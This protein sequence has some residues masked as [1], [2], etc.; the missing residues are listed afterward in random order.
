M[1]WL[2]RFTTPRFLLIL[3]T[4][5]YVNAQSPAGVPARPDSPAVLA[6]IEKAKQAA[7]KEWAE[8]VTFFCSA[9]KASSAT[10]PVMAPVRLFDNLY[11][12]GRLSNVG[13]AITTPNGIILIDAG[14]A[15][16]VESVLLAG[17][18]TLGLDPA[19]VKTIVV[20]HGHSDHFGGAPYF[21]EHYGSHVVLSGPDWDLILNPPPPPPGAKPAPP[22]TAPKKDIVAIEGTPVVLGHEKVYPVMTPGHT[23]GSMGLIFKVKDGKRTHMAAIYGGTILI[24][25][26][27]A[28][29]QL[30]VYLKSLEHFKETAKKMK[31]DVELQNHPIYDGMPEKLAALKDRTPGSPNPFVITPASYG[32]F[33]DV[34]SECM[35]A[36]LARR[37]E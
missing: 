27:I 26:R 22:V 16:D 32:Q 8:E 35:K 4:A 17:M 19:Q 5:G 30:Q 23:P 13:Y 11:A 1:H 14:Y 21:Q 12:I 28:D 2:T 33:L 20:T 34:Q 3:A 10:D 29:D 37:S 15:N 25:G 7:G 18:K 6:H 9:P 36:A 24:S 31:V